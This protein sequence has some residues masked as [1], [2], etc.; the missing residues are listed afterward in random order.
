MKRLIRLDNMFRRQITFLVLVFL[1]L[2]SPPALGGD[3]IPATPAPLNEKA[4]QKARVPGKEII[5]AYLAD[6]DY[7]YGGD[8]KPVKKSNFLN[9]LWRWVL[10]VWEEGM[11][12]LRYLPLALRIVFYLLCLGFIL[13]IA[14]KTKIYRIFYTDKEIAEPDFFVEDPLAEQFDFDQAISTQISHQNFR[15]AIRL[16][17]L[18][19]LKELENQGVIRFA[20]EKTNRE[21]A[22]E[23]NDN[24]LKS[25]FFKLA[26]VYNRVWFGNF[27]ISKDE[28]EMLAAGFYK[29]SEEL[30]GRKE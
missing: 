29:F 22:R 3:S 25:D 13:L 21:Y 30:N 2:I 27:T 8:Y 10:S 24:K 9:R 12:V 23:I 18:K 26:G 11:K 14:T 20:R 5:D 1:P 17:H 15:N 6:K 4:G 19:I 7:Q 28:Y 16:L